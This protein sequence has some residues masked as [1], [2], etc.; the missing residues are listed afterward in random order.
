MGS[1]SIMPA[2]LTGQL[3]LPDG[4]L[5]AQMLAKARDGFDRKIVVLDDDPTGVQTVHDL[6]VYT[7]W[8]C[9]TLESGL[10]EEGTMF[11]V[12]T[13]S[14]GFSQQETECVH[15]E[16]AENLLVVSE[17]T[18]VPF[19]LVS[20]GDSTLRGHYPLETETLRRTLEANSA[21]RYD[22]EII[23][24][25]FKEGG[26][27]TIGN[28][29]YVQTGDRL[30]PAGMTEFARDTTFAYN[31]SDLLVEWCEERTGGRYTVKDMTAISLEEL[32]APD[33]DAI[34]QKLMTVKRFGKVI[35]N[36]AEDRDV[37]VFTAALLEAVKQGK[38]FLIRS[39]AG[40]VRVLGN[41]DHRPLL[42][43][44]ELRGTDT[45]VGGLVVVGSHVKKTTEQLKC[46]LD[47]GLELCLICFDAET[48]F[49][50]NGLEAERD[51]VFLETE[52][53]LRS[54]KTAVVYTSRWVLRTQEDD[55]QGNL[56]LSVRISEA[57][58]SVVGE[59]TVRPAF[60]IAKGGITSSDVGIRALAVHRAWV[61][62][63]VAPGVPVWRTGEE[64]KFP[65]LSYVIF[66]GNV[67]GV[68]TLRDIVSML[69][70]P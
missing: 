28:V 29:H 66:P 56:N 44:K 10:T 58:T 61:M 21:V 60:L 47:A 57:L 64:S 7:D 11:F 2:S 17:K 9:E 69:L 54:G 50:P 13:N 42:K 22:G 33:Y 26:R 12:L 53:A 16:I 27:L 36:A 6:P 51:R 34:L 63:Q 32:R 14:R 68:T 15:R 65:G 18:S 24:P 20:R 43:R 35:V 8:R 3:P 23:M 52:R 59:L 4:A 31:A 45:D 19:L 37:D 5:V 40:L 41:V 62:G 67:G 49:T 1:V 25:Y 39:A 30:V 48:A 38:E 55:A 70:M 46:L